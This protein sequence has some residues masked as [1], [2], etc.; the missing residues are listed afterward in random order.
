[1][2]TPTPAQKTFLIELA[3][4]TQ[5][6]TITPDGARTM[7]E[8]YPDDV[9]APLVEAG[10]LFIDYSPRLLTSYIDFETHT[11]LALALQGVAS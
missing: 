4:A 9:F 10:M 11:A 1:M 8:T 6:V 3:L 5:P 7:C 2:F